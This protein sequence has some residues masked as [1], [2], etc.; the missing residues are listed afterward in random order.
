MVSIKALFHFLHEL[1]A[2]L[3][4]LPTA[5]A[6]TAASTLALSPLTAHALSARESLSTASLALTA[7][8]L[9]HTLTEATAE[10]PLALALTLTHSHTL[11]LPRRHS[12][13]AWTV[14][15][16]PAWRLELANIWSY[17][18]G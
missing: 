1:F 3:S 14:L 9:T 7:H 15:A 13:L 4:A 11:T 17:I 16:I 5:H 6:L 8:A 12:L 10:L 18:L 2:T